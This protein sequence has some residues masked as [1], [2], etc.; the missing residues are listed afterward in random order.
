MV[1]LANILKGKSENKDKLLNQSNLKNKKLPLWFINIDNNLINNT[2]ID[3]LKIL[4]ANFIV[5]TNNTELSNFDNICFVE[6]TK[7]ELNSGFDFLACNNKVDLL[8]FMK[9]WV[10]PIVSKTNNLWVLLNEFN[11]VKIEWNSYIFENNSLCD[12]YY[13]IIR[14]LE[15]FKFPYDNKAL[16][17][18]VINI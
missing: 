10:V 1:T 15:N 7:N 2:L 9:S 16:V 4:P 17:K 14:Y 6:D 8:S 3:A 18:N 13:A 12:I 11:A 5:Y